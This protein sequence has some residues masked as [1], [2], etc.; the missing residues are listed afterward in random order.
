MPIDLSK[1]IDLGKVSSDILSRLEKLEN[2]RNTFSQQATQ[3]EE[4]T[5]LQPKQNYHHYRKLIVTI[6]LV[7]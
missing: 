1:N 5:E 2:Q 3:K 6:I 4:K 7:M